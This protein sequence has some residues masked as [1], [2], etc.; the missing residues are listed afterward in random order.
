MKLYLSHESV[1]KHSSASIM[2]LLESSLAQIV[3]N[4]RD[5]ELVKILRSR[6]LGLYIVVL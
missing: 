1:Y 2:H 3:E 4:H 5:L 6:E